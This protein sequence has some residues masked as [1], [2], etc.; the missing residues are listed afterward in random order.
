[1]KAQNMC[2]MCKGSR[3]LCGNRFC[4]LFA[5]LKSRIDTPKINN[6]F[7]GPSGGIFVGRYGYPNVNIGP[8]TSIDAVYMKSPSQLFGTDYNDVINSF[9]KLVRA[10]AKQNVFS[11][12]SFIQDNQLLALSRKPAET[13]IHFKNI[14]KLDL[15]FSDV[16]QPTGPVGHLDQ[17]KI[18]ENVK[19][20]QKVDKIVS[21]DMTANDSSFELYKIGED[22]YKVTNIL[23]SGALGLEERKKLVP[24]RWSIVAV[25]DI[26]AKKLMEQIR[27]TRQ[28]DKILVAES[29][30]LSNHFVI[31]MLPGNWEFENFEALAPSSIWSQNSEQTYIIEE[32]ESFKGRTKYAEKQV[33]GYY[34]SR[35]GVTEGLVKLNRQARV[36]VFREIYEGY[37][38]PVGSWQI[39]ENVRNAFRQKLV[40]FDTLTE[41]LEYI[42]PK[43]RVNLNEYIKN[44]R[45]LQQRRLFDFLP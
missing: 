14:P 9:T 45:I 15:R 27:Y 10:E 41:A 17:M 5:K 28:I 42:R 23:S 32:Y 8:M 39:L 21:D 33:G 4:P 19:I 34:S 11:K 43:L 1:M 44:S 13:E 18:T 37:I 6:D 25:Y 20:A 22:V 29:E 2:L 12:A 38:L 36:V 40:Q 31:L 24:T 16:N 7:S 26:I 3:M 30:Y 35:L